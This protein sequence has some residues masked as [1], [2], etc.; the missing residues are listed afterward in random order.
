MLLRSHQL[1][2]VTALQVLTK[3]IFVCTPYGAHTKMA[4]V[5]GLEP[6]TG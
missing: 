5:A 4:Q 2:V 6:A 3:G 1:Q